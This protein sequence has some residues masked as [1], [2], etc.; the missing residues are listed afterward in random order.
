MEKGRQ[1][2]RSGDDLGESNAKR[3]KIEVIDRS[4]HAEVMRPHVECP[5][6]T[7]VPRDGVMLQC[8]NGHNVCAVCKNKMDKDAKCPQGRYVVVG[9]GL[10]SYRCWKISKALSDLITL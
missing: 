6:C 2:K 1:G 3:P 5:I 8:V 7:E 9:C 4:S 10:I